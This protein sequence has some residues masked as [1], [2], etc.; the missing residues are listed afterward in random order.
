L[1]TCIYCGLEKPED[2]FS[3]EHIWPDAL[4]GDY[5]PAEVWRT[6]DVCARCNSLSGVYVDGAFIRSWIGYAERSRGALEYLAGHG[7]P[8]AMP[9]NYLGQLHDLPVPAG[10]VAE[11]WAGPCGAN[12]VHIRPDSG[13]GQWNAYGG[14]D[15]KARKATAGRVYM[16][17]TSED[18][19]W[20]FTSLMSF[21]R[22]FKRAQRFVVNMEMPSGWPF[23]EPDLTDAVQ[24]E[25]MKAVQAVLDAGKRGDRLHTQLLTTR[26]VGTRMLA[27][28]ALGLGYKLLGASFLNTPY[29]AHLRA[30]FREAD[31]EK[32]RTIPVKGS[33]YLAGSKLAE[34][35]SA[36][37]WTGGWVLVVQ[38]AH[39]QLLLTVVAPSGQLMTVAISDDAALVSTL[40]N[41]Y[42]EGV[43]WI[44]VPPAE[45]AVGPKALPDYL[46][47][48]LNGAA[49]PDLEGLAAKRGDAGTLPPC[50]R[51]V[52]AEDS[53]EV[54]EPG[55]PP[56]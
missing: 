56:S 3:D 7:K 17:L 51:E 8:A 44:T 37:T 2:E 29:A 39:G 24:A 10:H 28:L 31:A 46:N 27:K 14:G 53:R 25:D 40:D 23:L 26:D 21:K 42:D 52:S 16:A 43:V 35:G 5:L 30:G 18:Q 34:L 12:I 19:F 32:R 54:I 45:E 36:L 55:P 11:Y 38:R 15:P 48:T 4:G 1:K 50:G 13:D 20:I 6:D 9:L 47:Y 22:H 41:V 33:G 49:D